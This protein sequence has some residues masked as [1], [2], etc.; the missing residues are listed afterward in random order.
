MNKIK[1]LAEDVLLITVFGGL[2]LYDRVEIWVTRSP[3]QP[4]VFPMGGM[5]VR[6]G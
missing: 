6:R 3:R 5:G 1:K 4:W 2:M